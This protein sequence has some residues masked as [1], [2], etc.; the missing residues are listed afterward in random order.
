M[1]QS[2]A[3]IL[4]VDDQ[5]TNIE[6][7]AEIFGDDYEVL[8][9]MDGEKALE[10]AVKENPDVI[11]LDVMMPDMDGYEVCRR[12]KREA[13]TQAIPVIFITGIQDE[14]GEFIGLDLGAADYVTKPFRPTV[15]KMR[16]KNQVELKQA[17]EQ[18]TQ[19][20][21]TDA[22]TGLANRRCFDDVLSL[23]H[24]RHAR[25]GAELS[26][27]MLDVDHFKLFN[28][29]Y[30]HVRGDDC[31]QQVARAIDGVVVRATDLVARYG[32]EEFVCILPGTSLVG[33]IAIAEKI[34]LAIMALAIPH[35]ASSAASCVTASL[36][37][38]TT[39]C[40]LD[41]SV[42]NIVAQADEQLYAAKSGGR[43]RVGYFAANAIA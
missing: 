17:R 26:V 7:I 31:L 19:M 20:V 36:G 40:D 21:T 27:I 11:L 3:R 22:M 10:I 18:L 35:G 23:E 9:A 29:S 43:N 16:V 2:Q 6:L 32:G 5:M 13:L 1:T 15:V 12:L 38:F 25:S 42:L 24:A 30:G 8:F 28:D 37:V 14:E 34:R 33:A 4:V 41:T 39:C